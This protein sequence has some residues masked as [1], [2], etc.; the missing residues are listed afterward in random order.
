MSKLL[1]LGFLIGLVLLVSPTKLYA[2]DSPFVPAASPRF[3][4]DRPQIQEISQDTSRSVAQIHAERLSRHFIFYFNR[5]TN[6]INRFQERLDLLKAQG[7][8]TLAA[9]SGLDKAKSKLA[10]AKLAGD[11][12]IS[13]FDAITPAKPATE[14]LELIAARDLAL[15][16]R[17]AFL[18]VNSSLKIAVKALKLISK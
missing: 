11:A 13:A 12:A 2:A 3:R 6:I 1:P 8:N 7:V 5:E 17:Q 4:P 15:K 9:Q 10:A 18:D 16:A 14:H